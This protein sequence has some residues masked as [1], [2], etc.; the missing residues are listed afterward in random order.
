MSTGWNYP[1]GVTG[2]EYAISG[3][4]TE[5]EAVLWCEMCDRE[6]PGMLQ[7]YRRKAWF[8]CDVCGRETD[9][10]MVP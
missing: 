9:V 2:F 6:R 8:I 7:T 5:E 10:E 1:P 4:D 3:A